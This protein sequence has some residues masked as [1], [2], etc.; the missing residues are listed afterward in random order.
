MECR[1][2]EHVFIP[3]SPI[4]TEKGEFGDGCIAYANGSRTR[5]RPC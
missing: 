3:D 2:E 1:I 5:K 4:E